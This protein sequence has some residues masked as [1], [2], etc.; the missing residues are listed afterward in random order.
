LFYLLPEL[1]SKEAQVINIHNL[2]HIANDVLNMGC[3]LSRINCFPFEST[4]GRI[5]RTFRT[6]VKPLTQ[7][8]RR[9]YE[10]STLLKKQVLLPSEILKLISLKLINSKSLIMFYILLK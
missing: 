2:V 9:E 7:V 8:C 10:R 5:K 4:L 1:Y 3:S 6:A